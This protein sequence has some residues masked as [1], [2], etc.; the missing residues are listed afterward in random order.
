[1]CGAESRDVADTKYNMAGVFENQGNL[2]EARKLFLESA[3]ISAAVLGDDHD[4]TMDAHHR[5]NTVGEEEESEDD[6]GSAA[7]EEE[8]GHEQIK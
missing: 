3:L 5:A 1:M 2:D 6:D 8:V 4:E 7:G